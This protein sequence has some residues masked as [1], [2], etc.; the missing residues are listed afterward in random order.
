MFYLFR[1]YFYNLVFYI[2]R[3]DNVI[4]EKINLLIDDYINLEKY[5]NILTYSFNNQNNI[6]DIKNILYN[7][8]NNNNTTVYGYIDQIELLK[9]L[10]ILEK[11]NNRN[12][13]N[14]KK[15]EKIIIKLSKK[16]CNT[17]DEFFSTLNIF[18]SLTRDKDL[19]LDFL[20]LLAETNIKIINDFIDYY[21]G[22]GEKNSI[23][24][25]VIDKYKLIYKEYL[26]ILALKYKIDVD[27]ITEKNQYE[28]KYKIIKK[29]SGKYINNITNNV[30]SFFVP[31]VKIFG[32][33]A[34][35]FTLS[36]S[37]KGKLSSIA[38]MVGIADVG[39]DTINLA[40]KIDYSLHNEE[41]H[42]NCR[43]IALNNEFR[44]NLIDIF[45]NFII[46]LKNSPM[47]LYN[48]FN[49][50]K[51]ERVG[52]DKKFEYKNDEEIFMLIKKFKANALKRFIGMTKIENNEDR[53]DK[54]I[55]YKKSVLN[56][57]KSIEENINK[58]IKLIKKEILLKNN[59]ISKIIN[60]GNNYDIDNYNKTIK[61]LEDILLKTK[62]K[63]NN[64]I[65]DF[66]KK[67]NLEKNEENV[68]L[69][70]F[71]NDFI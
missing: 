7:R 42:R 24:K 26:D 46:F 56:N 58:Q 66:E 59:F 45:Y 67:L 41:I 12:I 35:Y 15:L 20:E 47:S 17:I 60:G 50:F 53:R 52:L 39:T 40:K 34:L 2:F 63:E 4:N 71:Y 16:K 5:Q 68:E 9:I 62:Q 3:D 36:K 11:D 70:H 13:K 22:I 14:Y 18:H 23:H 10:I 55:K 6:N 51:I 61:S 44:L 57:Q 32:K 37:T 65:F 19:D 28:I 29:E 49:Y 33:S 25:F 31:V 43:K 38:A 30:N 27:N 54:L 1:G 21:Y 69:E 8:I 64:K 48:Y